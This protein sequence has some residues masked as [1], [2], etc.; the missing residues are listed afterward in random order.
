MVR[1]L[2]LVVLSVFALQAQATSLNL[3]Q[4]QQDLDAFGQDMLAAFGYKAMSPATSMGLTGFSVGGYGSIVTVHDRDADERLTGSAP[5]LIGVTGVSLEK[6]IPF[7]GKF[8]GQFG[9]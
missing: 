1:T 9:W 2:L 5:H 6:G 7:L 4:D 8:I 3:R